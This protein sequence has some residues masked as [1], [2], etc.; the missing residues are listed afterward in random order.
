MIWDVRF[1]VSATA[2]TTKQF[3]RSFSRIWILCYF[4][5]E[6]IHSFHSLSLSFT[7]LF[8]EF[9]THIHP[10]SHTYVYT[11]LISIVTVSDEIMRSVSLK[12]SSILSYYYYHCT[13]IIFIHTHNNCTRRD[14]TYHL[15]L[16]SRWW[17]P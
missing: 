8:I 10:S 3:W 15:I 12:H 13:F 6:P 9:H 11:V 17:M 14:D 16:I 1:G 2:T 7:H 5:L 4:I